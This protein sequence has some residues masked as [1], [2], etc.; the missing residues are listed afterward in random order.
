M[1]DRM[2]SLYRIVREEKADIMRVFGIFL[3]L[4]AF[5]LTG[6]SALTYKAP[7][8][9]A[10]IQERTA[11]ALSSLAPGDVEIR[12]DGRHVILEGRVA[13]EQRLSILNAAAAV[14]GALGPIDNLEE[15]VVVSPYRFGAVKDE[16]GSVVI[17]GHAPTA[18]VK[19]SIETDTEA[20]FGDTASLQLDIADGAP[21]GDWHMAAMTGLDAL[22]TMHQGKL[23]ITDGNVVL[24]G[25]VTSEANV[26]AIDIFAKA[27]PEGY[28]WTHDVGIRRRI[29]EPFTF[30]VSKASDGTVSLTG[31]APDKA[32]RTALIE[33]GKAAGGDNPVI[34]DI[35]I[36]DGM[37]DEEW[38]AL[39]Q[40]GISAM[41]D[42]EAGRFDVTDNDV[43]F[44]STPELVESETALLES[45]DAAPKPLDQPATEEVRLGTVRSPTV[46]TQV[47]AVLAPD[48]EE[49]E[50]PTSALTIDKVEEGVWAIRGAVPD[51][52][53]EDALISMIKSR[54]G[55][56]GVD[57]ALD[58]VGGESD[59]DWLDFVTDHVPAL[60]EVRAGRLNLEA[61]DAHLIGVVDTPDDIEQVRTALA[62]INRGMSVD[63]QPI[64]PRP[65][66][67]LEM[68]LSPADGIVLMGA[69]PSGLSEGEA[70]LA[71]GIRQYDGKLE[72]NGRGSAEAWRR[73]LT[74]IG[75][76]LPAFEKIDIAL[77]EERPKVTGEV[78]PHGDADAIAR[79]LVLALG[80]ERQPL[81]DI[82][83][84]TTI[85]DDGVLRTNPLNGE[86]E[87]YRQGY[88][89]PSIEMTAD[90]TS[91]RERSSAM[92]SADKITFLRGGDDLDEHAETILN[93]LASLAI[94]CLESTG[95]M[96][97]I[98]G[99]TDS[100]GAA[101][102]NL[103]L[104]QDR[105]DVVLQALAARGVDTRALLAVGYGDKNPVADNA[106]G[107]GRAANRRIT[108]EWKASKDARGSGAEG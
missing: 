24:E 76:L 31:Y 33:E 59:E 57:V 74:D 52:R 38:P 19:N 20:L 14:P 88:W 53:S 77:G 71:L 44:S 64:D 86:S 66:A 98:G 102:M 13:G 65:I 45:E 11:Q 55:A 63:L 27:L 82:A 35:R 6:Y 40:A 75:T 54:A 36:A 50:T 1:A 34:A 81:V 89:L 18:E 41:K 17:E 92:L 93:G 5:G 100:R 51:Q 46:D 68:K 73:H 25:E 105:A 80:D 23:S 78:H 72:E 103:E 16:S 67:S 4:A 62:A 43:S 32:T 56:E 28:T 83:T 107:E 58:L 21:D 61:Y 42:M 29:A 94:F 91:C 8:I 96:L 101:D 7:E 95:L 3:C 9:E 10:E 60:D 48:E 49:L 106:T 104:S 26:E 108:F 87:V 85:H 12:V 37:P 47:D 97:E 2:F 30:S 22:A 90:E 15:T 39:V 70:L 69:L 79:K 99:H 84:T